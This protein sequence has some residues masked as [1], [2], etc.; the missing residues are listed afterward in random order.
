MS[1]QSEDPLLDMIDNTL[2]DYEVS[3][4]AMRYSPDSEGD[5][6]N[7]D[8]PSLRVTENGTITGRLPRPTA[9]E[10]FQRAGRLASWSIPLQVVS[11]NNFNTY[12]SNLAG[13]IDFSRFERAVQDS[14]YAIGI[15][16]QIPGNGQLAGYN[17]D[18]SIARF[19]PYPIDRHPTSTD[20][21]DP[22]NT[23]AWYVAVA[24]DIEGE[25]YKHHIA[26]MGLPMTDE[27]VYQLFLQAERVLIEKMGRG[28]Q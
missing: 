20:N 14:M 6:D 21:T 2:E 11:R 10:A 3:G 12:F 17:F 26:V 18:E 16:Y 19:G 28:E 13:N 25:V 23:N 9:H 1:E 7:S 27:L 22:I 5:V 8:P 4:D 15:A 24:S